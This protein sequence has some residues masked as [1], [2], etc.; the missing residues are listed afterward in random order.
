MTCDSP[1]FNVLLI[2]DKIEELEIIQRIFKA[3]THA[4]VC[5]DHVHK[6]SE[7]FNLL[8]QNNYDLVLL[9]NRLSGQISAKFS[10]PFI[11]SSLNTATLAII[12]NDINVPYLQDPNIL[13]VNHVVDKSQMIR[14]LRDQFALRTQPDD[15]NMATASYR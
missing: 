8:N 12:S 4:S 15:R 6:C 11:T 13:G 10:V 1:A 3:L 9:D 2:D 14:F 7:A 5:I